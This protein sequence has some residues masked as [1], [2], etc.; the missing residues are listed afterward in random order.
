[1]RPAAVLL[2][3]SLRYLNSTWG[4]LLLLAL[5]PVAHV[6]SFFSLRAAA[7]LPSLPTP[8]RLTR[9]LQDS[10]GGNARTALIV[11]ASPCSSNL[12]ESL[13]TLRFGQ[14]AKKMRNKP[15]VNR[16]RSVEELERL[17]AKA[18]IAIDAQSAFI[19]TLQE[20]NDELTRA[21]DSLAGAAMPPGSGFGIAGGGEAFAL[22]DGI[23][24]DGH[25]H[26]HGDYDGV[27]G[28]G[29]G[30]DGYHQYHDGLPDASGGSG[31][32]HAGGSAAND[33]VAPGSPPRA[34]DAAAAS[35][36]AALV[37]A[38]AGRRKR[39]D[40]DGGDAGGDEGHDDDDGGALA[41]LAGDAGAGAGSRRG[42]AS[43]AAASSDADGLLS[44][45]GGGLG[46]STGASG[47][48]G[49]AGAV[50]TAVTAA[51]IL[52]LVSLREEVTLLRRQRDLDSEELTGRA[53]EIRV[54]TD[55]LA[56]REAELEKQGAAQAADVTAARDGG[57]SAAI[58]EALA[59]LRVFSCGVC[60]RQPFGD[61]SDIGGVCALHE[62]A[63]FTRR[64][65]EAA[66]ARVEGRAAVLQG[67][68][69]SLKDGIAAANAKLQQ[70][71]AAAAAAIAAAAASA[72][73]HGASADAAGVGVAA[74]A[75]AAGPRGREVV[76]VAVMQDLQTK[77]TALIHVH[78]QLLRKYAVVDVECGE[79]AEALRARDARIDEL[80]RASLAHNASLGALRE[81]YEVRLAEAAREHAAQVGEL[82]RDLLS[83]RGH[84]HGHGGLGAVSAAVLGSS[85]GAGATASA[86]VAGGGGLGMSRAV[87]GGA[88][89][90]AAGV[91]GSGA[92]SVGSGDD[93]DIFP[94]PSGADP[95]GLA[96]SGPGSVAGERDFG[97]GDDRDRSEGAMPSS[98]LDRLAS[99]LGSSGLAASSSFIKPRNVVK[100]I[101]GSGAVHGGT[102]VGGGS[103]T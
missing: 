50:P 70:Q 6:L 22:A 19:R 68:V 1:M 62:S 25:G 27:A 64:E 51:Q 75:A 15:V 43:G 31:A 69:D 87:G 36:D 85:S 53:E 13:S 48:G 77:L 23:A 54:L 76:D 8:C 61:I 47:T 49:G 2:C 72:P 99:E 26:G 45:S 79:M 41:L 101:R 98:S 71:E 16:V 9:L 18:E 63:C 84:G 91:A 59:S 24:H 12:V 10:L 34:G 35:G 95:F 100:P 67:E 93:G 20:Q 73:S 40:A 83:L 97:G 32:A 103:D 78:R 57:R 58:S 55:N 90:G 5:L 39:G 94:L 86:A 80:T 96:R 21:L 3:C 46:A 42:S 66:L 17:L 44:Q 65:A 14:R 52:E 74:G 11:C 37:P 7:P 4:W 28:G 82:R 92:A 89:G 81:S 102:F 56:A 33:A 30:G 29:P 60:A 88:A 38:T